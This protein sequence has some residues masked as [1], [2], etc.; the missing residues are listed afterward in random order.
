MAELRKSVT[1]LG[2]VAGA[3]REEG[4]RRW[5]YAYCATAETIG[6]VR[7]ITYTGVQTTTPTAATPATNTT[8]YQQ[9]GVASVTTTAA[10]WLWYQIKGDAEA[11]V[12][13][14]TDVA[15]GDFLEVLTTETSFK[16]DGT[17]RTTNSPCIAQEAQ[18]ANSSV[19]TNVYL[20][21]DL[22]F[23]AAS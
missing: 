11:L 18:A 3:I 7:V 8:V 21:G 15:V 12:E 19:L 9:V 2:G 17:S 5:I 4:N 6:K 23:I 14:T 16:K 20:F 13:G 10:G 1:E 22:V